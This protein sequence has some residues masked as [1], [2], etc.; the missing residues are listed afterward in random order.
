M[1]R[2][3]SFNSYFIVCAD[4]DYKTF[5]HILNSYRCF[6]C[7][8]RVI[9]RESEISIFEIKNAFHFRVKNHFRQRAWLAG[10][11]HVHLLE[12]IQI[13]MSVACRMYK[14]AWLQAASSSA[15]R[16]MRY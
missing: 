16:M 12:M 4:C 2:E 3:T 14:I 7:R 1:P 6:D 15:E 10:K 9:V 8:M 13:Y 11:L 5:F